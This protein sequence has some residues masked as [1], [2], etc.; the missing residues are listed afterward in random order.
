MKR[1]VSGFLLIFTSR[2]TPLCPKPQLLQQMTSNAW[3]QNVPTACAT[4][5]SQGLGDVEV[6]VSLSS[7]SVAFHSSTSQL[8]R[9]PNRLQDIA[10]LRNHFFALR[11]GQS[12]ANVANIIASN[13]D[14]ACHRYGLS[15]IGKK[16][17][18]KAGQDVLDT[19]RI[20]AINGRAFKGI[21]VISSDLLR[22][23]ETAEAVRIAILGSIQD[24]SGDP[25]CLY[26]GQVVLD[27]RLRERRFGEWDLTSDTNYNIVWEEDAVNPFHET[28]GV[29]AVCSVMDR[30]T[31][32]VLEWDGRLNDHMIVCVAH[33]DVLQILQTCFSKLDGSEHRTLD[34]L[35]TATLR[36]LELKMK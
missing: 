18:S 33:G 22:A 8:T 15:P 17:A 20:Q 27:T 24:A 6:A 16:Q 32:C 21:C 28:N 19:Y 14:I 9:R 30:V 25:I 34:H 23:K 26:T 5:Q 36:Q 1:D 3:P 4:H 12:E 35:E 2:I 31:Q 7:P 11:H 13:P 10:A 29:E